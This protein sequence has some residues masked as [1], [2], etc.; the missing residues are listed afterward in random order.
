MNGNRLL[1]LAL[2][3]L[4]G[5]AVAPAFSCKGGNANDDSGDD[6]S[7]GGSASRHKSGCGCS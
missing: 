4:V 5:L 1:L 7:G 6:D 3:A 2:I